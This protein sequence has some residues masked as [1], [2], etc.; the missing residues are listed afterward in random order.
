MKPI[1][2]YLPQFHRT[3]ENDEWWGEG[4]TEWTAVKSAT[5]QFKGHYQPKVP[6][7]DNY[8]DLSD[9]SASTWKW[10]AE[11]ANQYGLYGFAIYH[12]WLG[13]GKQLLYK[14]MEILLNHSEIDIKYCVC[15]A[16]HDWTRAWYGVPED[17]L[18]KQEYGDRNEWKKHF[19]YLLRF[20]NDERYIK[21]DNKPVILIYDTKSINCLDDMLKLWNE[22]AV[23]V[24]F[25]GVY[26]IGANTAN[27]ID[28]NHLSMDAYYN[29]E[30]GYTYYNLVPKSRV[31]I[32][33]QLRK[34]RNLWHKITKNGTCGYYVDARVINKYIA[35]NE[36]EH[37]GKKVYL[38]VF[39]QWDNTPRRKG[40]GMIYTHTTPEEFEK[41]LR[42]I[43][44]RVESG[45]FVFINAWNE[46]GEGCYIEPDNV[47]GLSYLEAVRWATSE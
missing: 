18:C 42:I 24:G 6:L 47:H 4:Y 31:W 3:P 9:E 30:A 29:F 36:L 23:S 14:P 35:K 40:K 33:F 43:N 28:E 12:Y 8:Y 7:N 34:V 1:A 17:I 27:G 44:H 41:S 19:D 38:G 13:N 39:P 21:K 15:W 25:D 45:D 46:W 2:L 20:F 26:S 10:Q 37:N 22:L 16:N 32:D 5:P 11:L